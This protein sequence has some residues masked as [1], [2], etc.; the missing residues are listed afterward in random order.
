MITFQ[1]LSEEEQH[2]LCVLYRIVDHHVG[3]KPHHAPVGQ[4]RKKLVKS[5]RD[6]T[7]IRKALKGLEKKE[8]AKIVKPGGE[9]ESWTLTPEGADLAEESCH[10]LWK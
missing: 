6:T 10:K 8:L 2:V 7:K 1:D 5:L 4:I 9:K 3:R